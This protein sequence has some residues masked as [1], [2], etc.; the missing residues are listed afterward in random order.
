MANKD[1]MS[2]WS[3]AN[4]KDIDEVTRY[5]CFNAGSE[6]FD[7]RFLNY[8]FRRACE[9]NKKPLC[10]ILFSI[11]ADPLEKSMYGNGSFSLACRCKGGN[12]PVDKARG[13][14][15]RWLF[16]IC[17]DV[18]DY[19]MVTALNIAVEYNNTTLVRVL[20]EYGADPTQIKNTYGEGMQKLFV[21]AIKRYIDVKN[22]DG[23][24]RP[25]NHGSLS[26]G[27]RL[28]MRTLVVIAKA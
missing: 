20:L 5:Q 28:A 27:F 3:I 4:V 13:E 24:W 7:Q 1:Y 23:E 14:L 8:C 17:V 26:I 22:V 9:F 10:K 6:M 12:P 25:G 21:H 2:F 11:G 16:Q 19:L 18:D 15:L